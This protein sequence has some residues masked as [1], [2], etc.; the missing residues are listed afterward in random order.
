[1][2]PAVMRI[3]DFR[4]RVFGQSPWRNLMFFHYRWQQVFPTWSLSMT[5]FAFPTSTKFREKHTRSQETSSKLKTKLGSEDFIIF[6]VSLLRFSCQ[7][8]YW[9]S[10][11]IFWL[12]VGALIA[13]ISCDLLE[14][15]LHAFNKELSRNEDGSVIKAS[16]HCVPEETIPQLLQTLSK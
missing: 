10:T 15:S 7:N 3:L 6:T 4:R 16:L 9:Q 8:L 1:M 11:V 5:N 12:P 13:E 14:S 2:V